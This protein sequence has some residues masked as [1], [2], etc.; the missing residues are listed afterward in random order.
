MDVDAILFNVGGTVFDW[1]SAVMAALETT[2]SKDL[3][4]AD[5]EAFGARPAPT[6]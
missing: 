5:A 4:S 6:A 2:V 3:R 1:R